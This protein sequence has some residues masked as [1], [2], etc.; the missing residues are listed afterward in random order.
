VRGVFG[1]ILKF[2]NPKKRYA[3]LKYKNTRNLGDEI[4]TIAAARF[5]PEIDAYVDR[6]QLSK[7]KAI[8]PHKIILNG[9]FLH[10]P[11]YWPPT[12]KLHPLIISFHLTRDIF[13]LNIKKIPPSATVLSPEGIEYLRRY[14]PVGARD[15]DTLSQLQNAGVPA[16][17]SGCMTLTLQATS[18][19]PKGEIIFAVD[20]PEDI[21]IALERRFG[22][23]MHRLTHVDYSNNTK[24]RFKKAKALLSKYA[25][26]HCVVTTRLHCALPCLALSTPVLFIEEASDSYRFDG[27]RNFVHKATKH[28]IL[29]ETSNFDLVSPPSNGI[30]WHGL[31]DQLIYKCEEFIRS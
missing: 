17:F 3:A 2:T 23:K 28:D 24:E 14:S 15:I 6:E 26:A 1:T 11:E 5:L 21:C 8:S 4:Q 19:A 9:W 18:A 22:V 12:P 20:V 7:F 13:E 29:A 10:R 30:E 25:S 16:Y 31:R 27:L